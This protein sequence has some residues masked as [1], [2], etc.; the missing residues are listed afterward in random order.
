MGTYVVIQLE[1]GHAMADLLE[2]RDHAARAGATHVSF[3]AGPARNHG[4]REHGH[5]VTGA[6]G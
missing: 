2:R 1:Q 4:D 6:I 3:R 5:V